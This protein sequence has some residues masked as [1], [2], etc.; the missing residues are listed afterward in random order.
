MKYIQ[1]VVL[2]NNM[3]DIQLTTHQLILISLTSLLMRVSRFVT[4]KFL[5]VNKMYIGS[6][7]I[8]CFVSC[9]YFYSMCVCASTLIIKESIKL[10]EVTT[11]DKGKYILNKAPFRLRT[12][13]LKKISAP[14]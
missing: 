14:S 3:A 13:G 5:I 9:A 11:G 7:K 6:I 1:A 10:Y 2:P 12:T 8:I 4:A